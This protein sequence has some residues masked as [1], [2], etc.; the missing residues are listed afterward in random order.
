MHQAQYPYDLLKRHGIDPVSSAKSVQD[1]GPFP[2]EQVETEAWR[3]LR[4]LRTRLKADFFLYQIE[5]QSRFAGFRSYLDGQKRCLD[6]NEIQKRLGEDTLIVLLLMERRREAQELLESQQRK[7]PS[8][9]RIAHKLALLS[10]A[11]AQHSEESKDYERATESWQTAI[12]NWVRTLADDAYWELWCGR[13][14]AYYGDRP[15]DY[16]SVELKNAVRADLQQHLMA[17]FTDYADRYAQENNPVR[18]E[19][20]RDLTIL[21][22]IEQQGAKALKE[23]GG[24]ESADG[25][26]LSCGALL[27]QKLGLELWLG[28]L[29]AQSQIELE[30]YRA[31]DLAKSLLQDSEPAVS[32]EVIERL[33][34]F[35]SELA[36]AAALLNLNLP[37]DAASKLPSL[38]PKLEEFDRQNPAYSGLENKL[39]QFLKDSAEL[40]I[41][42]QIAIVRK[43]LGAQPPDLPAVKSVW[44]EAIARGRAAGIAATAVKAVSDQAIGRAQTLSNDDQRGKIERL[45]EAIE[46]LEVAANVLPE[47]GADEVISVLVDMLSSRG[48]RRARFY[49]NERAVADLD[50]AFRKQPHRVDVRNYLCNALIGYAQECAEDNKGEAITKLERARNLAKVGLLELERS[51]AP[52]QAM[53]EELNKSIQEAQSEL[54]ML[55]GN[56]PVKD[57][58]D[59]AFKTLQKAIEDARGKAVSEGEQVDVADLFQRAEDKRNARDYSGAIDELEQVLK[60]IPDH[61]G[62]KSLIAHIYGK[63][64]ERHLRKAEIVEAKEKIKLGLQYSADHPLILLVQEQV[65]YTEQMLGAETEQ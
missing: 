9:G 15:V 49:D 14:Q 45:N 34:F 46:V 53:A 29:V 24:V 23:A 20:H 54:D 65:I 31:M 32:G 59:D 63:W 22:T 5:D 64:A 16:L 30:S 27:L 12:A 43:P 62:A 42:A 26:Q 28:A 50:I 33:C 39:Q 37:E 52:D 56:V 21:C 44:R 8:D 38:T 2:S 36:P 19:A 55:L 6:L 17:E 7:Q 48:R 58:S 13:R 11:T 25:Q 51:E 41:D 35:F 4:N 3:F 18:A 1:L 47:N 57:D 10:Y 61:T 40:A 60:L